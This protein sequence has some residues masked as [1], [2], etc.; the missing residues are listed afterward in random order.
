LAVKFSTPLTGIAQITWDFDDGS[1]QVTSAT[2]VTHVYTDTG[3][4]VPSVIFSNGTGCFAASA[5]LDTIRI[6]RISADFSWS[7]PCAGVP[8]NLTQNS[9][10]LFNSPTSWSWYFS[11]SSDTAA[12]PTASYRYGTGG[13]HAVSLVAANNFGCSDTIT[14]D[15]FINYLPDVQAPADTNICPGDTALIIASGATSYAWA[16][17]SQVSCVACD[18]TY[19]R[20]QSDTPGAYTVFTVTGTDG[21]GCINKD[22]VRVIIQLKTTAST[23]DGGEICVGESFRLHA[24]GAQRYEWLPAETIDS[25]LIASPLATPERTTTYIVAAREGTCLVDSQRVVVVVHSLPLFSAG[26]D[27]TIAAGSVV[28]LKPTQSGITRIE[29][30]PDSTLSCV[31][32]F[33][34]NANPYYTTT[35]YATGYNEF[36]CEASDSV[37]VFVR[38]NGNL[39]FVPNTFTP[40]GD[41]KNDYFFPRG[42][43]ID[44]MMTFRVFNRWG[45]LVFDRNN[46][47]VNDERAGWDG[48]FRGR[49]L[50]PDV[51]VYTMQSRCV[52]GEILQWKGDITLIR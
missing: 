17:A 34:P 19:V 30:R 29:W 23:G 25:P 33:R 44:Q 27:E 38:C 2:S 36:G 39:V 37:T 43:G 48:T 1:T 49:D 7:V 15:V 9:S 12:G 10:A 28:T 3:I 45:E 35:Y 32:C 14:K 40:N 5:G 24:E 26:S 4:F 41:G 51:Y 47:S 22:S 42:K 21:N 31:D 13:N 50:P 18:S 46:V 16:P 11:G 6:D 8:F 52:T 20:L